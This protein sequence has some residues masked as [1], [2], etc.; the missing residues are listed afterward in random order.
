VTFPTTGPADAGG[1]I[2]ERPDANGLAVIPDTHV[3]LTREDIERLRHLPMEMQWRLEP[4]RCNCVSAMTKASPVP[5]PSTFD[6]TVVPIRSIVRIPH[7]VG[8]TSDV[9]RR[10]LQSSAL[11]VSRAPPAPR[12]PWLAGK[13][14]GLL[15]GWSLRYAPSQAGKASFT[16]SFTFTAPYPDNSISDTVEI[17]ASGSA[18]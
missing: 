11:R 17:P 10:L 6:V 12:L 14:R 5:A 16:Y 13:S 18:R 9:E 2:H 8:H 4:T 15:P 1:N 3:Q 7:C